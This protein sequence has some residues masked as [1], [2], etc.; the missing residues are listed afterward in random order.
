MNKFIQ[1]LSLYINRIAYFLAGTFFLMG[2]LAVLLQVFAR[3]SGL[4]STYWQ[5]ELARYSFIGVA[6]FASVVV[7]GKNEHLKVDLFLEML[8]KRFKT[9]T[10]IL[11]QIIAILFLAYLAQLSFDTALFNIQ[12][13]SPALRIN[14]C[15]IYFSI[16]VACILMIIQSLL[17]IIKFINTE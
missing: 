16:V 11:I 13:K 1:N 12:R 8:P 2:L 3:Q 4:L 9:I 7:V 5:E 10:Q 17:N 14:F 6:L 15:I